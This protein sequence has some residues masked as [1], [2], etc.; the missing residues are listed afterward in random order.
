MG[1]GLFKDKTEILRMDWNQFQ[2]VEE[3]VLSISRRE[4]GRAETVRF[5]ESKKRKSFGDIDILL[6]LPS[7]YSGT[8]EF[9]PKFLQNFIYKTFQT[10]LIHKND[11]VVSFVYGI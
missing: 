9:Y 8:K 7:S 6:E 11:D 2:K 3:D 4:I 1:G 10:H 5:Y